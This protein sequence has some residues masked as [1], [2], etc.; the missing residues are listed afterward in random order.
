MAASDSV[1]WQ[2]FLQAVNAVQNCVY[3]GTADIPGQN[4]L[5]VYQRAT[6]YPD[7]L[8]DTAP[9]LILVSERPAVRA[10]QF[11]DPTGLRGLVDMEFPVLVIFLQNRGVRP[12]QA[13]LQAN[14][15]ELIQLRLWAPGTITGLSG[16][17]NEEVNHDVGYEPNSPVP[18]EWSPEF[19]ATAQRFIFVVNVFRS[20]VKGI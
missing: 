17:A 16:N 5:P 13:Q 11:S 8:E 15:E 3:Q 18:G 9:A 12:E 4:T 1:R 6:A 20:N 10:M 7:K 2:V 19:I 14:I